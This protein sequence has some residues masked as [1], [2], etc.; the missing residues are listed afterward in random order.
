MV[1]AVE[2]CVAIQVKSFRMFRPREKEYKYLSVRTKMF[3]SSHLPTFDRF[4]SVTQA[5]N[6]NPF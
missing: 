6:L 3:E 2:I 4:V 5:I 1:L